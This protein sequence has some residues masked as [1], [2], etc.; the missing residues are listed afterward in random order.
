ME[1]FLLA[2]DRESRSCARIKGNKMSDRAADA[3][4]GAAFIVI[5]VIVVFIWHY[6]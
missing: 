6:L 1:I 5:A 3:L 4:S 2:P